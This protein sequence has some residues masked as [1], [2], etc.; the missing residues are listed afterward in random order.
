MRVFV[1]VCV[2]FG[3]YS[4]HY[5]GADSPDAALRLDKMLWASEEYST[6]NDLHGGGCWARVCSQP[7]RDLISSGFKLLPSAV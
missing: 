2:C 3:G 1:R 7:F 6:F 4:Q 5:P